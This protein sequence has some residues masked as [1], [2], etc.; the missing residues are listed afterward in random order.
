MNSVALVIDET[1]LTIGKTLASLEQYLSDLSREELLA[2]VHSQLSQLSGTFEILQ[3]TGVTTLLENLSVVLQR[4]T[5]GE[6][7]LSEAV[8]NAIGKTLFVLPRYVDYCISQQHCYP[9]LINQ[10][11]NQLAL[12]AKKSI[13]YESELTGLAKYSS[14]MTISA[15][16]L[17]GDRERLKRLHHMYQVGLLGLV[18]GKDQQQYG[19]LMA[20]VS[21]KVQVFE[22]FP[23]SLW[24]LIEVVLTAVSSNKLQINF[25]RLRLLMSIDNNLRQLSRG[26]ETVVTGQVIDELLFLVSIIDSS[27]A[28]ITAILNEHEVSKLSWT[29]NDFKDHFN[30]IIGPG[31]DT[32]AIVSAAI[33]E[34]LLQARDILELVSQTG[35]TDEWQSLLQLL[36]KTE[37]ILSFLSLM[38]IAHTLQ[39]LRLE[40]ELAV[41]DGVVNDKQCL[42]DAAGTLLYIESA[43]SLLTA[44]PT[45]V[46]GDKELLSRDKQTTVIADVMLNKAAKIVIAEGVS[47]MNLAKRSIVN[48]AENNFDFSHIANLSA[49]LAKVAGFLAILDYHRAQQII[50]KCNQYIATLETT[51]LSSEQQSEQVEALAD[52][53]VGIEYYIN[54]LASTANSN[55][56]LLGIA[57]QGISQLI[58]GSSAE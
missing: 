34:E 57:E 51:V 20:H 54:E 47:M 15:L 11:S 30:N 39:H 37:S 23:T 3:F 16:T 42:L 36:G 14:D 43:L 26:K 25:T 18:K 40:L 13:Q 4:L 52:T 44:L 31:K 2:D 24:R 29:D 33:V 7:K 49:T 58:V 12:P 22:G 55:D 27:A 46:S 32:V 28:P 53:L 10:F 38:D 21:N 17:D 19:R 8:I 9:L 5:R 6:I 56:D 35:V 45:E 48:Y 50:L 41:R 1:N